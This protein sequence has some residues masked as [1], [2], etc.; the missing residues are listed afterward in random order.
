MR[1][2][3]LCVRSENATTMGFAGVGGPG[4]QKGHTARGPAREGETTLESRVERGGEATPL[5]GRYMTSD[6]S[7]CMSKY[8][9]G[10]DTCSRAAVQ[11]TIVPSLCGEAALGRNELGLS[12]ISAE[13]D[14]DIGM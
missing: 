1:L 6:P 9:K 5:P 2:C 10:L 7:L 13:T 11:P 3:A 14:R 12:T 4:E 8:L